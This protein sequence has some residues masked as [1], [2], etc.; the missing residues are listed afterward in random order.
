[1][2]ICPIQ[3][4]LLKGCGFAPLQRNNG[5]PCPR[6]KVKEDDRRKRT[7]LAS[8][9]SAH[10]GNAVVEHVHRR[11]PWVFAVAAM[12]RRRPSCNSCAILT[13]SALHVVIFRN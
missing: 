8:V 10:I 1:M 2:L 13:T 4:T 3:A 6:V 7:F 9:H 11:Q 5:T 12:T